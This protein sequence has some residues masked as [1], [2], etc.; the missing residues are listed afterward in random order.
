MTDPNI[1]FTSQTHRGPSDFAVEQV[2]GR[3][4]QFGVFLA[5]TVT[6]IGAVMFLVQHGHTRPDFSVFRGEPTHLTTLGG[7]VSGALALRSEAIVQLGIVLLIATPILRVAF[8]LV[9]FILQRDLTYVA[10]TTL[11]LG[12]LVYGLVSGKA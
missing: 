11:V 8:T 9:A 12:L 5:A 2:I 6:I 7:I 10:V 1:P 3:L 4:L